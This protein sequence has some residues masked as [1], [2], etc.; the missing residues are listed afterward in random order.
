MSEPAPAIEPPENI[1]DA[2]EEPSVQGY[3]EMALQLASTQQMP[4]G[5]L[6]GLLH[7]YAHSVAATVREEAIRAQAE[8]D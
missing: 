4:P 1:P 2:E 3:L 6:M 7:Y 8:E 5:E